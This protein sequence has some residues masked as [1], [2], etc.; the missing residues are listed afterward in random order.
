MLE[1]HSPPDLMTSLE[2]S[3]ISMV[4]SGWIR[5]TSPVDS[6]P[7]SVLLSPR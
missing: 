2:R 4:P 6:Q 3:T 5:A 7:L 1:I